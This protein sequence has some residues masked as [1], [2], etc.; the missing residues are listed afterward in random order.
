M[1]SAL[2]PICRGRTGH[3]YY[4]S[5]DVKELAYSRHGVVI[6]KDAGEAAAA[7]AAE[8]KRRDVA[9]YGVLRSDVYLHHDHVECGCWT[10][11]EAKAVDITLPHPHR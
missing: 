8:C 6:A 3:R 2:C 7:A 10:E 11:T 4:W 5:V 9:A 1:G